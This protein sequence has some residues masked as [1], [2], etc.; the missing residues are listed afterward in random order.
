MAFLDKSQLRPFIADDKEG[1]PD[2]VLVIKGFLGREEIDAFLE[3]LMESGAV[4]P[5]GKSQ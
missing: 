3:A 2:T 1:G 4:I 5:V